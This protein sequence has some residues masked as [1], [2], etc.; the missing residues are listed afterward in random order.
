[1]A[2]KLGDDDKVVKL[3]TRAAKG[4]SGSKPRKPAAQAKARIPTARGDAGK[5]KH[6]SA[7]SEAKLREALQLQLI[8]YRSKHTKVDLE[9][10]AIREKLKEKGEEKKIIRA[11]IETAGMPLA[12]FDE[13][14]KDGKTSRVDLEKKERLRQII[15]EAYGLSSGPQQSFMDKLPE[16]VQPSVYWEA[17]GYRVGIGMLDPEAWPKPPPEHRNDFER[18]LNSAS[19]RNAAGIKKLET[20]EAD[21]QTPVGAQADDATDRDDDEDE[22]DPDAPPPTGLPE[23]DAHDDPDVIAKGAELEGLGADADRPLVH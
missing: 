17:E 19:S 7:S 11:A 15:R 12:L 13:S 8:G 14:Y 4:A 6:R 21:D 10:D 16:A 20:V 22:G 23:D 9:L 3:P 5:P 1:M 18:G 2:D